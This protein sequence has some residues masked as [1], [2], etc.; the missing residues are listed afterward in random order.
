MMP[1]R[2][3]HGM[4]STRLVVP[5]LAAVLAAGCHHN[6]PE[7]AV[8][9][10][11][12]SL[13]LA[14]RARADSAAR[15]DAEARAREDSLR[16]AQQREADSVAALQ[17]STE[18]MK[19]LLAMRINFDYDRSYIRPSDAQLLDQKVAVLQANPQVRIQVAGNCDE[20]GSDEYNL[21]LG[22]RRAI[23]AKTYLLSHGIDAGRIETVSYGE[24]RPLDPRHNE[25]AWAL[26]RNDQFSILTPAVVL[27]LP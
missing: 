16:L 23:S 25:T 9:P 1:I 26:N 7:V 11:A 2:K 20:R 5:I 24:E 4:H 13:A 14:E 17:R 8:T 27:R 22:N 12:D 21:A 10:N 19:Q 18:Q 6:P 3:E 15:A